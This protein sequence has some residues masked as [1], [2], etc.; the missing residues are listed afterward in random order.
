MPAAQDITEKLEEQESRQAE[1][2]HYVKMVLPD[3]FAYHSATKNSLSLSFHP[4]P[5]L[6]KIWWK[7]TRSKQLVRAF[8]LSKNDHMSIPDI[9]N[10]KKCTFQM[11]VMIA[12]HCRNLG[13]VLKIETLRIPLIF[14]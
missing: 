10:S 2:N 6:S 9:P 13:C 14:H 12:N 5:T 11:L 4:D 7:R 1:L 3:F 8:A